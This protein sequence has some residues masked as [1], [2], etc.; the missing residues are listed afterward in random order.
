MG[1]SRASGRGDYLVN[2]GSPTV[3][4]LISCMHQ[5]DVSIIKKTNILSDAVIVNQCDKDTYEEAV[6]K[7]NKIRMY[8]CTARGLSKSRN[9]A[10]EE[11]TADICLICDDDEHFEQDYV[12]KIRE[13]Y[14]AYPDADVIAFKLNYNRPKKFWNVPKKIGYLYALKIASWQISFKR[15]SIKKNAIRFNES[16]GAG[17]AVS[18]GEEN[19][20]LYDCLKKNLKIYYL[21]ILIGSVT[22]KESTWFKGFTEKFFLNRGIVTR[23]YMGPVLATLYALYYSFAKYSMYRKEISFGRSI[24][25][26][27]KGIYGHASKCHSPNL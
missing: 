13:A 19:I 14:A 1:Y 10:V 22:Q 11:S 17:T 21:P 24:I 23:Y 16:F 25:A 8:S 2:E 27:M 18:S 12:L 9:K 5:S 26:T 4:V 6:F 7:G 20:F 3:E 15:E